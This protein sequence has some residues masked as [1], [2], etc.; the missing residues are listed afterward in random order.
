MDLPLVY[1][2]MQTFERPI[3]RVTANMGIEM[4]SWYVYGL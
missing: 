3:Q 1:G 2:L 4:P